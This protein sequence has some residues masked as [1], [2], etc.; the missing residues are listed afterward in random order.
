MHLR[1]HADSHRVRALAVLCSKKPQCKSFWTFATSTTI[2]LYHQVVPQE[3]LTSGTSSC[4]VLIQQVVPEEVLTFGSSSFVGLAI[5]LSLKRYWQGWKPQEAGERG[6]LYWTLH[7]Y[8]LNVSALRWGIAS[9]PFPVKLIVA[10]TKVADARQWSWTAA[11]IIWQ[12]TFIV[13][14]STAPLQI[15]CGFCPETWLHAFFLYAVFSC[16]VWFSLA[17]HFCVVQTSQQ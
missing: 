1:I 8:H 11:V 4:I 16:L 14:I 15:K 3:V 12:A 7:S 17:K 9:L 6:S 2:S 5:S 10:W 13:H